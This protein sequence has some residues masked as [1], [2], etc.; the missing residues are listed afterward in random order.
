MLHSFD[1]AEIEPRGPDLRFR[2]TPFKD[3][4]DNM[5]AGGLG[6]YLPRPAA[7]TRRPLAGTVALSATCRHSKRAPASDQ[8]GPTKARG[9]PSPR[10]APFSSLGPPPCGPHSVST[11]C[12]L[13]HAARAAGQAIGANTATSTVL[14]LAG[15]RAC[16]EDL[17][18]PWPV[19]R[20]APDAIA[21][22]PGNPAGPN[23]RSQQCDHKQAP[24]QAAFRTQ[25]PMKAGAERAE[26]AGRR[27]AKRPQHLS[28]P[29]RA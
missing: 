5:R 14:A 12:G 18:R 26:P 15:R 21:C 19:R 27:D 4:G 10:R 24:Q 6:S 11:H 8:E 1:V 7:C 29:S 13:E 20:G 9:R 17:G 23:I 16:R 28:T 2:R 22:A 25:L 3:V